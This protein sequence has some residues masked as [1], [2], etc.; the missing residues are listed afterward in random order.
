MDV[1]RV[2]RGTDEYLEIY[3]VAVEWWTFWKFPVPPLESLPSNML[4]AYT[5]A[6]PVAIGFIY[7]TDSSIAWL[8]WIVASPKA[9][10]EDRALAQEMILSSVKVLASALGFKLVFTSSRSQTLNKRL[11][12]KFTKTDEC[13]THF[14]WR[15]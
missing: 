8:E 6:G 13:M 14:I 4:C 2:V 7:Q 3:S 11:E 15:A 9:A 10:K 1:K 5:E 12:K